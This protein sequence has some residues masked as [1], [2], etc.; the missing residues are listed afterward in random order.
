[1]SSVREEGGLKAE[2]KERLDP[3]AKALWRIVGSFWALFLLALGSA[4]TVVLTLAGAPVYVGLLPVLGALA[5]GVLIVGVI[6]A[7]LWRRWRYEVRETEIDLQRG[8]LKVRRTLV[9]MAR[10]QHVDTQHGPLQ[11]ALGLSTV[12]FYTAAGPNQIPQLAAPV[13]AAVRDRIAELTKTQDE[14]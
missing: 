7:V 10:V 5:L 13:A 9:P 11:R 2:P 1:M 6:P 4:G 8:L 14:L 12:I 3:R